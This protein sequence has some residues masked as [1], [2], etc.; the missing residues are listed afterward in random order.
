MTPQ[1]QG[2]KPASNS[3]CE[4]IRVHIVTTYSNAINCEFWDF[5]ISNHNSEEKREK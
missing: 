5:R 1:A 3:I 4:A 2:N